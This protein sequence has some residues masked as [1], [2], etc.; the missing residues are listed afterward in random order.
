MQVLYYAS[1]IE[2]WGTGTTRMMGMCRDQ[3]L[4]EPE[5]ASERGW[6]RITFRAD[7]YTEERLRE[8]GLSERQIQAVRWGKEHGSITNR[9]FRELVGLSDETVRRY[10]AELVRRGLFQAEGK[11]KSTRYILPKPGD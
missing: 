2:K 5:F 11:G 4:P 9:E 10:L 1:L 8:M 7:P 6:F 3:D